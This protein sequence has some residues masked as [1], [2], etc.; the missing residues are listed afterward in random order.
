MEPPA[1]YHSAMSHHRLLPLVCVLAFAAACGSDDSP[2]G[3]PSSIE[4]SS[5]EPSSIEPSST[6]QAATDSAA[7][8]AAT[9]QPSTPTSPDELLPAA[10]PSTYIGTNQVVNLAVMPDGTSPTLDIWAKRSFEYAPILLVEGLEYGEVSPTYGAPDGM[11]V[12]AV[13]AGTGPDAEPFAGVFSASE[14]QHY[15]HLVLYDRESATGTGLLLV[16][17]DPQDPSAFPEVNAGQALVQLYA[18]Q[19]R[20]NP[21]SVGE[22]FDQRIAGVEPS[23]QIGIEGVAGCAPQPR[24]TDQGYTPAVLGGTQYVPFDLAPGDTTFTFHGWGSNN[25]DCADPSVIDPVTV[26]VAD[27]DR[28]WVLLHSRDGDTIEAL[29]VPAA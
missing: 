18:Y 4:P 2:V 3:E 1:T 15:T 26:T 29:V 14:E 8:P 22:G 21:L 28:A 6:E 16:D 19:L 5:I 9:E 12:V 20:L 23:F 13:E 25:Q 7:P 10:D 24:M 17:T 11:S 27:G